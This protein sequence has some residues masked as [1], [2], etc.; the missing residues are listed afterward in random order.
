M[1]SR[2]QPD[3]KPLSVEQAMGKAGLEGDELHGMIFFHRGD[4]SGFVARRALKR[5]RSKRK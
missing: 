2:K 4:E 3:D 5:P 1:T